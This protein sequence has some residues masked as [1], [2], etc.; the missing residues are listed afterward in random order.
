MTAILRLSDVHKSASEGKELGYLLCKATL[1]PISD[2]PNAFRRYEVGS[3][4]SFILRF[5]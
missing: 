2:P 1:N 3:N 5:P 4:G